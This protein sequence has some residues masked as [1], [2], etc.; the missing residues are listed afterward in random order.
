MDSV[1]L[2][3]TEGKNPVSRAFKWCHATSVNGGA[4]LIAAVISSY[5]SPY[6]TDTLKIPAAAASVIMFIATL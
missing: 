2:K 6:M 3:P 5:F 1:N 4:M